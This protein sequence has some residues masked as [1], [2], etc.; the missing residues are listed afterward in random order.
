MA[1]ET[2]DAHAHDGSYADDVFVRGYRAS[3]V[4]V[5]SVGTYGLYAF[6]ATDGQFDPLMGRLPERATVFQWNN[7]G[8]ELPASAQR[9]ASSTHSRNAAFR[10][11]KNIYGVNFHLEVTPQV[12][13][14]WTERFK[15][16]LAG[17]P[18][19]SPDKIKADTALPF[20][21]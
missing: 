7:D 16:E 11:G 20:R 19:L 3:Y 14:M 5:H 1:H 18:Y 2:G 4:T 17:V 9:L 8:I 13:E 10:L 21:A 12:I 6:N 15:S